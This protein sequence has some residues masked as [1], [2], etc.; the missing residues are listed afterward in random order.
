MH[1]KAHEAAA[2]AGA[3]GAGKAASIVPLRA[4]VRICDGERLALQHFLLAMSVRG[5]VKCRA[6]LATCSPKICRWNLMSQLS[7]IVVVV[8]VPALRYPALKLDPATASCDTGEVQ[9][10]CPACRVIA[11]LCCAT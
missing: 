4:L 1:C 3:T 8:N 5:G 6:P 10:T 7:L 9:S 2:R 11:P